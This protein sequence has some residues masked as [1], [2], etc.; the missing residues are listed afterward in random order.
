M[1]FWKS[2]TPVANQRVFAYGT[3]LQADVQ[4]ELY[5]REVLTVPDSLLGWRLDWLTITDEQVIKTSG[6]DRHPVLRKGTIAD[7]VEGAY[8]ELTFE[9]LA[10]TDKYEV[11][12]YIRIEASLAS[13]NLAFVYVAS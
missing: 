11:D 7:S 9:E 8:L 3:L 12:D 10:A 1:A 2:R 6:S 5:G 4:R 13:G